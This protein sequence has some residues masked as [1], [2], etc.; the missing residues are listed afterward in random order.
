VIIPTMRLVFAETAEMPTDGFDAVLV[1]AKD[2]DAEVH[3]LI[4]LSALPAEQDLVT[5]ETV[6]GEAVAVLYNPATVTLI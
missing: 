3:V 1:I 6:D 4:D 2:D 5:A